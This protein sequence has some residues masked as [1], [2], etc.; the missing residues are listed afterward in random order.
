MFCFKESLKE[1]ERMFERL[2]ESERR[3]DLARVEYDTK[4]AA[5]EKRRKELRRKSK[6]ASAP[7]MTRELRERM[8]EEDENSEA[9]QEQSEK[10]GF[11]S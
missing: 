7:E 1:Y 8:R 5:A 6:R 10:R 3:Q 11:F 4:V 9:R 2:L